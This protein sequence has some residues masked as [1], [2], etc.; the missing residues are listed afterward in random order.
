MKKLK[1][2]LSKVKSAFK[3]HTKKQALIIS[4]ITLITDLIAVGYGIMFHYSYGDSIL[5]KTCDGLFIFNFFV[6]F[7]NLD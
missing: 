2:L 6:F 3:I 4:L 7:V 5:L 1:I